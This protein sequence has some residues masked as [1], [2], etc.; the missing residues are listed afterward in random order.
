LHAASVEDLMEFA[1]ALPLSGISVTV[2]FKQEVLKA[3]T[4]LDEAAEAT[5][6]VNTL[7]R[8]PDG[9][10]GKNTDVPGFR[11]DLL[12]CIS[13]TVWGRCA[14]VLGAGGSARAVAH[15]LKSEGA[16]V[17]VWARRK[18]QA[19][20]LAAEF[21]VRAVETLSE[22]P[23]PVDV[24]VNTTPCGMLG[25]NVNEIAAPWADL[26][27]ALN[28]DALVYDLVYEPDETLLLKAAADAGFR[29]HNGL[30]MLQ[31]QAALQANAFGYRLLAETEDA[32]KF[33]RH[34]WLVGY[35]GVGKSALARELAIALRRRAVDIDAQIE[36]RH[37]SIKSIFEERGEEFFRGLEADA[38]KAA[39]RAKPDAVIA[40]GGGAVE[41]EQNI[42]RMRESGLVLWLE[43]QQELLLKRLQADDERPKL[44]DKE[45]PEE[46]AHVLERRNPLYERAAHLKF[47]VGEKSAREQAGIIADRLAEFSM[48]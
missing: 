40:P 12:T 41:D 30:G 37:G 47:A 11:D 21:G 7:V 32:P 3:C 10:R 20:E 34:V 31:R 23:R 26:E 2:P 14:L 16:E 46:V 8:I 33:S 15:T 36:L 43:A 29:A 35:R 25:P 22:V 17:F 18:E 9:W 24:L 4:K 42:R 45:L 5:G 48:K 27:P 1:N 6:A 38:I 13:H 19:A 28:H 39:A 44:T